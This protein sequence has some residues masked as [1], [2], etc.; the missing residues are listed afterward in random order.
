MKIDKTH[1]MLILII[2]GL[3]AYVFWP[4]PNN[5]HIIIEKEKIIQELK[6]KN[7]LFNDS[8]NNERRISDSLRNRTLELDSLLNKKIKDLN[9]LKYKHSQEVN[10]VTELNTIE[11]IDFFSGWINDTIGYK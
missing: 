11:S 9:D 2:V 1:I 3:T 4:R 10:A 5:D 6:N 8:L 7:K